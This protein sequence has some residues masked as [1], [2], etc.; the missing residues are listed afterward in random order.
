MT[1]VHR[2]R[3]AAVSHFEWNPIIAQ[4]SVN[5]ELSPITIKTN[6]TT[7]TQNQQ[8]A[9]N[10]LCLLTKLSLSPLKILKMESGGWVGENPFREIFRFLWFTSSLQHLEDFLGVVCGKKW[11]IVKNPG[12]MWNLSRKLWK[13]SKVNCFQSNNVKII[14]IWMEFRE[15]PQKWTPK[16]MQIT[17]P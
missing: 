15:P 13:S 3:D 7:Q 11:K 6:I 16:V 8:V 12:K 9:G 17:F 2:I 1:S 4:I 5:K 14:E 10:I